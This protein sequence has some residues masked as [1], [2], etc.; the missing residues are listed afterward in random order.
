MVV[1]FVAPI[2]ML[3]NIA[4]YYVFATLAPQKHPK[5]SILA[6]LGP[7]MSATPLFGVNIGP[8]V[9]PCT[10]FLKPNDARK[11]YHEP[12]MSNKTPLP[13][14]KVPEIM[15]TKAKKAPM[16]SVSLIAIELKGLAAPGEA[17]KI[18]TLTTCAAMSWRS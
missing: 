10:Q 7:T 17:L 12:T 9:A 3:Q 6:I 8:E 5:R 16:C 4:I 14:H 13:S 11:G 15:R 1:Y 18:L 2:A